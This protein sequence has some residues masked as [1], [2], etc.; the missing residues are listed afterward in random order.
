[1]ASY[2]PP[3]NGY[4][5]GSTYNSSYFRNISDLTA[6]TTEYLSE[7][8]LKRVGEPISDATITS[9]AG[10]VNVLES[11]QSIITEGDIQINSGNLDTNADSSNLMLTATAVNIAN[12]STGTVNVNSLAASNLSLSSGNLITS[13][14]TSNLMANATTVNIGSLGAGITNIGQLVS[15]NTTNATSAS[16]GALITSGGIGVSQDIYMGGSNLKTSSTTMNV[17]NSTP[18]T[19]KFAGAATSL[20]MGASTGTCSIKNAAISFPNATSI[21][22]AGTLNLGASQTKFSSGTGYQSG[23]IIFCQ[24]FAGTNYKMCYITCLNASAT[25]S[26]AWSVTYTFPVPYSIMVSDGNGSYINCTANV[27]D[28]NS[29][30]VCTTTTAIVTVK[31]GTTSLNSWNVYGW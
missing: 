15:N 4:Y 29:T 1:M 27:A 2:T 10:Q 19:I 13:A 6:V 7:N 31:A 30:L 22:G 18:T 16:T 17:F 11:D 20:T 21:T 5:D 12:Q 9:F 8:Y 3:N 26:T 24:P 25:D 28:D 14:T 23:K